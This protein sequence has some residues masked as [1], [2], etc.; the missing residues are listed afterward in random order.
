MRPSATLFSQASSALTR[1]VPLLVRTNSKNVLRQRFFSTHSSS[2]VE[3]IE[4]PQLELLNK[5]AN[6]AVANRFLGL[7]DTL[8]VCTQPILLTTLS[9]F[10]NMFDK[11]GLKQEN[12]FVVAKPY[13]AN[14]SAVKYL[15]EQGVNITTIPFPRIPGGYQELKEQTLKDAW[16]RVRAHAKAENIQNI[17]LMDE[18]G[19]WTEFKPAKA[20]HEIPSWGALE[21]T[22]FGTRSPIIGSQPFRLVN[23]AQSA[24]KKYGESPLIA[25]TIIRKLDSLIG[26]I[27]LSTDHACG[28]V[29][30]GP[31]G[32]A[33][34]EHLLKLGYDVTVYDEREE[35][36]ENVI[37]K[38]CTRTHD[39]K[40]L[41]SN[42]DCIFGCTGRDIFKGLDIREVVRMPKTFVSCSS[43]DI[44]FLSLLEELARQKVRQEPFQTIYCQ[45]V[46]NQTIRIVRAGYPFNFDGSLFSMTAEDSTFTLG[47]ML[48][49]FIQSRMSLQKMVKNTRVISSGGIDMLDPLIQRV[50]FE[51]FVKS[52]EKRFSPE[53]K[54][55]FRSEEWIAKNSVGEH[56][57]NKWIEQCFRPLLTETNNTPAIKL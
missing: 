48:G 26:E 28:V 10:K 53:L 29:G 3:P 4:P 55:C 34:A 13:S 6:V 49:G 33:I 52:Q 39:L 35:A 42:S 12:T 54:E 44:E 11:L 5:I 24:A 25:Q 30:N 41:I 21:Q 20:T 36:F 32:Y 31:I 57:R 8:L 38:N 9:M 7:E 51:Q 27:G 37:H 1:V 14:L 15:E 16:Q 23:V 46:N 19:G 40:W 22:T 17:I 56:R 43:E 47:L 2:K 50:V 45:S 18:G